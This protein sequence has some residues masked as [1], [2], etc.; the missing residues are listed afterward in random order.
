MSYLV[1]R[2]IVAALLYSQLVISH[3]H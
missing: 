3:D 1:N 2:L